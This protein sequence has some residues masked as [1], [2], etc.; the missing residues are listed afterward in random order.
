MIGNTITWTSDYSVHMGGWVLCAVEGYASPPPPLPPPYVPGG[1]QVTCNENCYHTSDGDCDDGGQGSEYSLCEICGDCADCGPR[2]SSLCVHPPPPA[3]SPPPP[4][5]PPPV[6]GALFC[7]TSGMDYC[8]P[9]NHASYP[10]TGTCVHDGAGAHGNDENCVI[11]TT[12][13]SSI[14]AI[15]Y[16][17]ETYYDYL[18]IAYP[19]A[20]G[21][22]GPYDDRRTTGIANFNS[23]AGL[24]NAPS[25]TRLRWY[26]DYSVTAA[27]FLVC[28][29]SLQPSP[30]PPPAPP[31]P[32]SPPPPPRPPI[33]PGVYL[34]ANGDPQ[35]VPSPPTAPG[36]FTLMFSFT[37]SGSVSDY[38]PAVV[39]EV[40]TSIANTA[41]VDV[42]A[43]TVTVTS[44][45][46][47]LAVEIATQTAA[48][49]QSV[50][51]MIAPATATPADIQTM[52]APVSFPITV[53]DTTDLVSIGIRTPLSVGGDGDGDSGSMLVVVIIA[54]VVAV[55]AIAV[56]AFVV[57]QRAGRKSTTVVRAIPTTT[58]SNPVAATSS[59]GDHAVEMGDKDAI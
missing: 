53:I 54:V 49:A 9:T 58:I 17:V 33:L 43:V 10:G 13:A 11:E 7:I 20:G 21:G 29:S 12:A 45:S 55:I 22:Y 15:Q 42:N 23:A 3:P 46:V 5:S 34:D 6:C 1:L 26:A 35:L 44:G 2:A 57:K 36:V 4:P 59:T 30:P 25:G 16:N 52:L 40:R 28:F 18:G 19:L 8:Q 37:A 32:P 48:D 51:L 27:G 14:T 50:E 41:G 47:V 31:P 24:T 56:A 39:D 38:T